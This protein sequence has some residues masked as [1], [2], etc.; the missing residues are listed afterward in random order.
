[1]VQKP[2]LIARKTSFTAKPTERSRDLRVHDHSQTP[3]ILEKDT[4]KFREMVRETEG[5][6]HPLL[7]NVWMV[8][9]EV[10]SVEL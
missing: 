2:L 7:A 8:L 6:Q 3:I 1:M 10:A 4:D 9:S 5:F